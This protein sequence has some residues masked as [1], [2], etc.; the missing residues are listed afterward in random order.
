MITSIQ[1]EAGSAGYQYQL[2][3]LLWTGDAAV[4]KDA[5]QSLVWLRKAAEQGLGAAQYNLGVCLYNGVGTE[6]DEKQAMEW[7]RK[8]DEQGVQ[9]DLG[10]CS[11]YWHVA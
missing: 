4:K 8:A 9:F 2:A 3:Q 5:A 1:A 11:V 10:M 6:K 7:F